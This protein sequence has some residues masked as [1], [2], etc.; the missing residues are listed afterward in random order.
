[1]DTNLYETVNLS[2]DQLS[3]VKKLYNAKLDEELLISLKEKYP[4]LFEKQKL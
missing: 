1:M 3:E 2:V 4:A